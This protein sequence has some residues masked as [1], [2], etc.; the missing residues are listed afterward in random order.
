MQ[1]K[2]CCFTGHRPK[3]FPWKRNESDPHCVWLKKRILEEVENAV[4]EGFTR[5]MAGGAQGVDMWCAEA[6]IEIR[7]KYPNKGIELILAIPFLKYAGYFS[8]D[9]KERLTRIIDASDER[10]LT[11]AENDKSSATAKYYRR[12]EYMVDNS[13]RIIAVFEDRPGVKGGTKYTVEYAKK[14][15][16]EIIPIRWLSD[17]KKECGERM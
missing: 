6:V 9:E 11:S 15:G 2:T 8:D 16:C 14:Q 1:N 3:T 7:E 12:N 4:R 10:I 17:Y 5:F 13:A